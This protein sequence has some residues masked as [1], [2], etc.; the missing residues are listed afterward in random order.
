MTIKRILRVTLLSFLLGT[1]T[2][3]S[4]L[5]I[6]SAANA[7]PKSTLAS[8]SCSQILG[9]QFYVWDQRYLIKGLNYYEKDHAWNLFWP[10]WRDKGKRA[11][12]AQELD[13]ARAL[14]INT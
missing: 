2:L 5:R 4:L 9:D 1:A 14:G 3:S 13:I 10:Y 12:V 8:N 6:A 11:T 7:A